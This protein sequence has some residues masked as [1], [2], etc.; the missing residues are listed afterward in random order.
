MAELHWKSASELAAMIRRRELKPSELMEA[1]IARI[2]ALNPKLNAF[3][4]MRAE[5]ALAEAR[6]MDDKIARSGD[7]PPLSGLPIGVKDL[8]D[9]AGLP[10]TFGSAPFRNH[11]P[12]RDS[13]QVARLKA[14]WRDRDR[15]DQRPRVRLRQFHQEPAVRRHT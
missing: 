14:A 11:T 1:T 3:C 9:A 15:Q 2:E 5:Q 12:E 4:A 6:A 8:E 7:L 13:I 10:T